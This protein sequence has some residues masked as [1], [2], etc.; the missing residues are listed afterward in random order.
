MG[1]RIQFFIKVM[2][3]CDHFEPLRLHCVRLWPSNASF[4]ALH[5]LNFFFDEEPDRIWIRILLLNF[6]GD[7][8]EDPDPAHSR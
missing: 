1:I 7:P 6:D 8:D 3:I 5:L 2:R 4:T